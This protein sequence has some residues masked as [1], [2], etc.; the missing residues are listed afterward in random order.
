VDS[1]YGI[2]RRTVN[3]TAC[4]SESVRSTGADPCQIQTVA[5]TRRNE[6]IATV[7]QRE[8][9]ALDSA[10]LIV[11]IEDGACSGPKL[12]LLVSRYGGTIVRH[13]I[14]PRSSISFQTG[15]IR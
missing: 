1:R 12:D 5:A 8:V 10:S 6:R 15:F 7:H 2:A 13:T 9:L 14:E 11:L 4:N 3:G